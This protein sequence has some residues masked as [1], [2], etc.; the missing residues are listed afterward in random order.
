VFPEVTKFTRGTLNILLNKAGTLRQAHLGSFDP[1]REEKFDLNVWSCICII[2]A[3]I[4]LLMRVKDCAMVVNHTSVGSTA[5]P[6]L[7]AAY[8]ASRA[9]MDMF[10]DVPRL[11]LPE[12]NIR[13][14]DLRTG[15]KTFGT[16][17]VSIELDS[18]RCVE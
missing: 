3:F 12:F 10:L 13:V 1:R 2:L 9:A 17:T 16:Q 14:I 7:Q 6:L 18:R 8:N 15:G 4:T 11:E 5:G